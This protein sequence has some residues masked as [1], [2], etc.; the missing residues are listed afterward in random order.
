MNIILKTYN[1]QKNFKEVNAVNQV[2]MTVYQGDIYGFVGE[3]GAG[4]STIIRLITNI[5]RPTSGKIELNL[6]LRLGAMAA[7]I[8]SPSLAFSLNAFDNL[9]YQN[10]LLGKKKNDEQLLDLLKL[11]G[12]E[13]ESHSHKKTHD[14]SLGMK[15][16]LA[17][18]LCLISDPEFILLDEPMNGLDPVGIKKMRE[19]ILKLNQEQNITFLISSHILSELDKVATRF[20]FISHG[21]LLQEITHKEIKD[22]NIE[23][24]YLKMMEPNNV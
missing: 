24:Y 1:L 2:N 22:Q 13:K 3:N 5:I 6:S 8:E 23:D 12:L 17:I 15:Q 18:A 11:V 10:D 19:L 4:K 21:K 14:F 7:I 16:R 9:R 20:G